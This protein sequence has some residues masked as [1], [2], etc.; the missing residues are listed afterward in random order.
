MKSYFIC[1]LCAAMFFFMPDIMA[2]GE[3]DIVGVWITPKQ[4]S[5]IEIS[6]DS[7]GGYV[8]KVIW[9]KAPHENYEGMTVM[10][11]VK[12]NP[13][14]KFYDCPWLYDPKLNIV[15]KAK[16]T[17]SG[18]KLNLKATKGILSKNEVFTRV[19]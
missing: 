1:C 16:I 17:L 11:G 15:A 7:A 10:K 5:K 13:A 8:A 14:A 3:D 2:M 19:N 18:N 4:D 9:A 6:K 12:Y